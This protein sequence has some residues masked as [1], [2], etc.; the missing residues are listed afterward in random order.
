MEQRI[1]VGFLVDASRGRY[2]SRVIL[3]FIKDTIRRFEVSSS[4][5]R[6]GIVQYTSRVRLI[7]G[8][9]R[10]YNPTQ[11]DRLI[12][13]IRLSGRSGRYLGKALSYTRRYL[14]KGRPRC[15]RRR[16]LIVLA[17]GVSRD[18]VRR[19]AGRL[20]ASGVEIYAIGIGRVRRRT[21]MQIAT[22]SKQVF[23][24]GTRRLVSL[25]RLIKDRICSSKG[26]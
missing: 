3:K 1:D 9:G 15:G 2:S 19:P 25:S 20:F 22:V 4:K 24:V 16:V 11:I 5:T 6:I 7:L 26:Q 23:S 18:G 8:L 12:D 10:A 14:F 21:L 17:T 13:R